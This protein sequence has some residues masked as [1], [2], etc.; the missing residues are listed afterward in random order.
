MR[1]K[2]KGGKINEWQNLWGGNNFGMENER[3]PGRGWSESGNL[4]GDCREVAIISN[5]KSLAVAR[6]LMAEVR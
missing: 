1:G 4:N 2:W 5:D 3:E 6:E